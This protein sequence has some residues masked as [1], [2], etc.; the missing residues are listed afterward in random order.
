MERGGGCGLVVKRL[1]SDLS[2]DWDDHSGEW[3]FGLVDCCCC[4]CCCCECGGVELG[5][6]FIC[7]CDC[8]CGAKW[9]WRCCC[10][11]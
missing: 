4:C 8:D 5:V 9:F 2:M 10:R 7:D 11:R 1:R 6:W 3:C